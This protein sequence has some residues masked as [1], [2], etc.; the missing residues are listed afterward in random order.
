MHKQYYKT[1]ADPETVTAV[2]DSLMMVDVSTVLP[3]PSLS[4]MERP[5]SSVAPSLKNMNSI[6]EIL[7][8][9]KLDPALVTVKRH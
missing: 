2:T 4:L 7:S 6:P 5:C 1:T 9:Q 3:I 8:L